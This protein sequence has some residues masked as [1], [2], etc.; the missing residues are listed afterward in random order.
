MCV[1]DS[2]RA[3]GLLVL[4]DALC[5]NALSACDFVVV[6]QTPEPL[7]GPGGS[8]TNQSHANCGIPKQEKRLKVRKMF[9]L[10][11][12]CAWRGICGPS[13]LSN[14][15]RQQGGATFGYRLLCR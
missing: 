15:S 5:C 4:F 3:R 11:A 1:V 2:A 6:E 13:K 14:Q 12:Q 10:G 9:R 8:S 7:D